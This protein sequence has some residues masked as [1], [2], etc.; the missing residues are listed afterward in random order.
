MIPTFVLTSQR[1]KSLVALVALA[2][3][4][5]SAQAPGDLRVALVIG[6]SSYATAPLLNPANDARA[7]GETLRGLGF[8]VIELRDGSKAQMA[9]AVAQLR[10]RLK[11]KA[12]VGLLYY[13][14]HGV[15]VDL[16]NYMVPVDA[17]LQSVADVQAQSVDVGQVID[18]FKAAGNRMN[19]VVLDACRD[20]PFGGATTG[21]GLAP[22]DAPS[23]TF[24]AYATAPGN[25]AEDGDATS[26]NGLYTQYLLAELKK[27]MARIEDVFKRVRFAVRRASN[28]RQIPWESTSLEDDFQFNDGRV[29]AVAKPTAQVLLA[30]FTQEQQDWARIKD[31]RNADDFYAFLARYPS[32]TISEAANA[33]LDELVR[34]D[35]VVQGAGADGKDAPYSVARY[36]LGDEF[37]VRIVSS[38]APSFNQT[39]KVTSVKDGKVLVEMRSQATGATPLKML[40]NPQGGFIGIPDTFTHT[41]PSYLAPSG[42]LQVGQSWKTGYEQEYAT[43]ALTDAL[44]KT[45][46][47]GQDRVVAREK[48]TVAAGTFDAFRIESE[49]TSV[50]KNQNIRITSVRW[51]VPELPEPVK[52]ENVMT[53]SAFKTSRT[54]RELVRYSRAAESADVQRVSMEQGRRDAQARDN[55][56]QAWAQLLARAQTGDAAAMADV[57]RRFETG[58]GM[59]IDMA[60]AK[61]WYARSATAGYP[62]GM[63]GLG[64][65]YFNGSAGPR[66]PVQAEQWWRKGALAGDGRSMAGLSLLYESGEGGMPKDPT[67]SLEW[68]TKAV[69]T[70]SGHALVRMGVRLRDGTGVQA[71]LP[72]SFELFRRAAE[73][74]IPAAHYFLGWSYYKGIGVTA[75]E[76]KAAEAFMKAAEAGIAPAMNDLGTFYER[77]AGGLTLNPEKAL[78]WFRKAAAKGEP[79][80]MANVKKLEARGVK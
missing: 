71:N 56:R 23:G 28:G 30:A 49:M 19:I 9:E 2:A 7:M 48:V 73:Q 59:A 15:Q 38:L 18:A 42:L 63:G 43:R 6:N 67:L 29:V 70:G 76:A 44:G 40:Y 32:G 27:P 60:Q 5:A 3:F 75:D 57:G 26:G 41:P 31:S 4:S 66:D 16:R 14:G 69:A 35:L 22:L 24:L 11:G 50:S 39:G 34:S 80:A 78:D 8:S 65:M 37:E 25:V 21:K 72:Q 64:A 36:R 68:L 51:V 33:R 13:A 12:G 62:A 47:V 52:T 77:G 20:N 54:T 45:T 53:E 46:A 1:L 55:Q 74:D 61:D 10:D 79:N 17:R 58:Q